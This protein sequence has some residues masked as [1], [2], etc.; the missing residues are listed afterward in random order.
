MPANPF[1]RPTQRITETVHGIPVEYDVPDNAPVIRI[2]FNLDSLLRRALFTLAICMTA[3][4]IIWGTVAIGSMLTLLAPPWGAYLVAGIFDAGW[5]GCLI[6]EW[7]LR[8]DHARARIPAAV[9]LAM[10]TVSVA[11]IITDGVR[12]HAIAVG[13]IGA[14]VSAAAKG[15]WAVAMYTIRIKLDPKYEA[16]LRARQQQAGTEQALALGERDR[17]LTGDRTARL[18]LALEA[19][20]PALPDVVQDSPDILSGRP[21]DGPDEEFDDEPDEPAI[22]PD[23]R[24]DPLKEIADK[25]AGP[26]GLVRALA[27]QGIREDQL[28]KEAARLR[29]D[30]NQDSI[31]RIAQRGQYL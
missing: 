30:L 4:A 1:R 6:A 11:A 25:A 28:L 17:L 5:A 24:P 21:D 15:M 26:S 10:L 13:I 7:V 29:P 22:S 31:R 18:L 19:R 23:E 27:A 8:Y 14:L 3:G 20:R 9:G 12:A 2:P 16:Y